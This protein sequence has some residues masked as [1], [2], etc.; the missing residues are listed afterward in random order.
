MC[1]C[2]QGRYRTDT[3]SLPWLACSPSPCCA[4]DEL[5]HREKEKGKAKNEQRESNIYIYRERHRERP[6][7]LAARRLRRGLRR[8]GERGVGGLRACSAS[9]VS[10]FPMAAGTAS[11]PARFEDAPIAVPITSWTHT[12][13]PRNHWQINA[14]AAEIYDDS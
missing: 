11:A 4:R 6:A 9:P 14:D 12:R 10:P 7:L 1:G 3:P 8:A 13:K 2:Y 5:V